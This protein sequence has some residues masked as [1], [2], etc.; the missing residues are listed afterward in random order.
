MK[1]GMGKQNKNFNNLQIGDTVNYRKIILLDEEEY[2][3]GTVIHIDETEGALLDT[4]D[5]ITG[6]D[7]DGNYICVG[8]EAVDKL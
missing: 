6:F 7:K 8:F 4:G 1:A 3:N 5:R 2:L